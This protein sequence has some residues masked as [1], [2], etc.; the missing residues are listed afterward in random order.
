MSGRLM[1]RDRDRERDKNNKKK[2]SKHSPGKD[3][4]RDPMRV[5]QAHDNSFPQSRW[6]LS[7]YWCWNI[8]CKVLKFVKTYASG[9]QMFRLNDHENSRLKVQFI[10]VSRFMV[11]V[12]CWRC[13][14]RSS[15]NPKNSK[16]KHVRKALKCSPLMITKIPDWKCNLFESFDLWW[17]VWC[18]NTVW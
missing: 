7:W 2:G 6:N 9:F 3:G 14:I 11:I 4:A 12:W 10:L 1:K 18:C 13:S 15:W 16:K 17:S 5:L 8:T